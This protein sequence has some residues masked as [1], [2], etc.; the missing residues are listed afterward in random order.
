MT[1]SKIFLSF[2]SAIT[3]KNVNTIATNKKATDLERWMNGSMCLYETPGKIRGKTRG[4]QPW[5]VECRAIVAGS[6][7]EDFCAC[8]F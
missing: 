6:G 7:T 5:N 2:R 3:I 4:E 1:Y 8:G